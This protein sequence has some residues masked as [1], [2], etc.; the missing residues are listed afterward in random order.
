MRRP[1]A[2]LLVVAAVMSVA[3]NSGKKAATPA[4]PRRGG[5]LRLGVATPASLDP[6]QARSIEETL[7]ADQLFDGVT[8]YDPKTLLAVPALASGWTASADQKQFDFNIRADAT[9]ESGRHVVAADVKYTLERIAKKGSGSPAADLLEL[10]SGY[11]AVADGSTTILAGVTTPSPLV[12]RIQLDQPLSA[13]PSLLASPLFGVV[14]GE[15]A[16]APHPKIPF[17]QAPIDGSGPF[18]FKGKVGEVLHLARRP[19]GSAYLAGIDVHQYK[20]VPAAYAAFRRGAVDWSRVPPDDVATA[21]PRYGRRLFTPYVAELFYAFNVRSPKLSDARFRQAIVQ[22]VDTSAI[23]RGVYQNTV[24]PI[25]NVVVKGVPGAQQDACRDHC[26]FNPD[27]SRRLIREVFHGPAPQIFLDFDEDEVQRAVAS[28]IS[29][30]LKAV[31]ITATLRPHSPND[32][33]TFAASGNQEVFRLGWIA[34]YPSPDAFLAPLFA[35]GSRSNLT[36]FSQPGVDKELA[37][38]RSSANP[39]L[40]IQ[41]YQRVENAVLALAPVLPIAQFQI[42]AVDRP[43]VH[44]LVPTPM[45]SFDASKVWVDPIKK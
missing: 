29:N 28:A 40:Q 22:A 4:T 42:Q 2:L 25:K 32:Y 8:T 26:A 3:C 14:A 34:P 7:L 43:T 39:L 38:A 15:A 41:A 11:K 19:K 45:A 1:L 21:G 17:A 30:D 37:L 44:G 6:A 9:F 24:L 33:A 12:L 20:D 13:L 27:A 23:I 36:G 5:V 10:I 16:S 31:G 35:N 18:V